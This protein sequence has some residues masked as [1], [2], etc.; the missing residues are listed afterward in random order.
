MFRHFSEDP[1][2]IEF[3]HLFILKKGVNVNA[4]TGFS[5]HYLGIAGPC[6][7]L[8]CE[9][10]KISDQSMIELV[11]LFIRHGADLNVGFSPLHDFCMYSRNNNLVDILQ[12]LI[13]N[14]ADVNKK[15]HGWT[16]LHYLCRNQQ[17]NQQEN[18]INVVRFLIENGA[19]VNAKDNSMQTPLFTLCKYQRENELLI[20]VI[21]LL[22]EKG[23]NVKEG[24]RVGRTP[25][26]VLCKHFMK[27]YYILMDIIELMIK[28][29]ADPNARDR[30]SRKTPLEILR[31]RGPP[32]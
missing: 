1:C 10:D 9:N 2:L 21:R 7:R 26:F 8:M 30:K 4:E 31:E 23:A 17:E 5:L 24:K 14:G 6:Y 25:L 11:Q 18:L 3:V 27:D 22:I 32:I 13:Q 29:G 19:D 12:L 16:P 20:D 15:T 28:N